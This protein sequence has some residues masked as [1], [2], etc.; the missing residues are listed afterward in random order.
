[1]LRE[2]DVRARFAQREIPQEIGDYEGRE[3]LV[4]PKE[5]GMTQGADDVW[6]V[7]WCAGG[8]YGDPLERDPESVLAD[9]LAGR[10]S[11]ESAAGVYAVVFAA[12]GEAI[13]A[14]ATEAA[15]QEAR[16]GR[17]DRARTWGEMGRSDD[18]G[19]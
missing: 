5:R 16:R 6:E 13:D 9:V 12:G 17:L 8:G 11:A 1:M 7:S 10:V 4:E 18:G 3:D 15:R 14:E 19:E 2:S